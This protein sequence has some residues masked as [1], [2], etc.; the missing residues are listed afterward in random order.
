[1]RHAKELKKKD[2]EREIVSEELDALAE[3]YQQL[4]SAF[5][6]QSL[7]LSDSHSEMER[8]KSELEAKVTE[9]GR[10]AQIDRDRRNSLSRVSCNIVC[11]GHL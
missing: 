4:E 8:L 10:F 11:G 2:S 1:M 3:Q 5:E 7:Q 9:L 6:S